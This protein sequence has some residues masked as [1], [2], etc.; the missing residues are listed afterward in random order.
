MRSTSCGVSLLKP[1]GGLLFLRA[2]A[3]GMLSGVPYRRNDRG[4][5]AL[6]CRVLARCLTGAL[7]G[8]FL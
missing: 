6:S 2:C 8:G 7:E 3:A 4:I 5:M 1:F